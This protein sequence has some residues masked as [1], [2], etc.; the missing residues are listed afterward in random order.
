MSV[1]ICRF[2][3]PYQQYKPER[4]RELIT[5]RKNGKTYR[6]IAEI[7]GGTPHGARSNIRRLKEKGVF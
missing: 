6:E 5:L 1:R 3:R 2:D 4:N 7:C